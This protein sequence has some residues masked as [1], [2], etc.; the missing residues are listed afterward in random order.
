MKLSDMIECANC[1][2]VGQPTKHGR[3]SICGSDGVVLLS[4]IV[5][6]PMRSESQPPELK[7]CGIDREFLRK[8]HIA[9]P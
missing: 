4:A 6:G 2:E 7:L 5:H 9:E 1:G 3:C 8:M